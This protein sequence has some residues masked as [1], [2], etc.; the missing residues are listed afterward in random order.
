MDARTIGNAD[1]FAV[2]FFGTSLLFA[3]R[4]AREGRRGDLVCAALLAGGMLATKYSTYAA[5]PLLLAALVFPLG[6][7]KA[8]GGRLRTAGLFLVCSHLPLLPWAFKAWAETGNP[9]FPLAFPILDGR[10]W[11]ATLNA[12]LIA[13]QRSLGMGRDPLHTLLLP[14]NA[15]MRGARGYPFF[16]GVLSPA[17]LLWAPWGWV[18]GG[19]AAR[20]ALLLA[21]A[22]VY[23][24]GVGPQQLRFL[25]PVVLLLA[26]VCGAFWKTEKGAF[27][28]AQGALFAGIAV[29]LLAPFLAETARDTL[30]VVLGREGREEYLMR[31][32]QSYEAFRRTGTHVPEGERIL[33]VWENRIYYSPRPV[34][35][36]S[37]FEASRIIRLAEEEA[38]E[39]A[40]L[41]RLRQEGFRWV[42]V[43]R[44]LEVV[45]RRYS[46][47]SAVALLDGAWLRC[48][49]V[50]S[51]NGLDLYRIPPNER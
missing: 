20:A 26:S 28:L 48:E 6:S 42:L 14:W 34:L 35:A 27:G 18:R 49:P 37:F 38:S 44:P 12:R 8:R 29:L 31:K 24:W 10:G 39:E 36:D 43:N 41:D 46:P 22:G 21:L 7:E 13:W 19:R 30:P 4:H 15:I 25:L 33:L 23:L 2:L 1:L 32:V 17:L 11:D 40:L 16:D 50:G 9:L 45:F 3:V 51:W 5:Y 47:E